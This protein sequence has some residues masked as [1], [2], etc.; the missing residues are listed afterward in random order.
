MCVCVYYSV[1]WFLLRF[2]SLLLCYCYVLLLRANQLHVL[3]IKLE[4]LY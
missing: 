2:V 4:G 1:L 3:C